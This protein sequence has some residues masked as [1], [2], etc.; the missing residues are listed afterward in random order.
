MIAIRET[1]GTRP[2]TR[3]QETRDQRPDY[4]FDDVSP[5]RSEISQRQ[6]GGVANHRRD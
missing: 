4:N 1:S 3:D 6:I 2:E 5:G